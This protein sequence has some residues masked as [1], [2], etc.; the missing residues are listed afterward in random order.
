MNSTITILSREAAKAK[1]A[2]EITPGGDQWQ[3]D[4]LECPQRPDSATGCSTI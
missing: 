1:R 2:P 4:T 3:D